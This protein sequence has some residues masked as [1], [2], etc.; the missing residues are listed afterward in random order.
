[1]IPERIGV[2]LSI[3]LFGLPALVL[4]F[5]TDLLVPALVGRGWEPLSAWFLAGTLAVAPLLAASLLLTAITLRTLSL[6]MI[7]RHFAR[8]SPERRRLAVG[9]PCANVDGRRYACVASIQHQRFAPTRTT[10]SVYDGEISGFDAVLSARA[11]AAVLRYQHH[12]RGVLVARIYSTTPRTGIRSRHLGRPRLTSLCFP[13][14]LRTGCHLHPLAGG[15][16][17]TVGRTAFANT[18]VGIL[19]HAGINGPSFLVVAFGLLP[20]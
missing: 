9:W 6:Q 8:S 3:A 17:H 1:M 5:A 2:A 7:M 10:S 16:Q 13:L 12:R 20:S 11:M 18:S 19:I 14:Q 4:W 15:V